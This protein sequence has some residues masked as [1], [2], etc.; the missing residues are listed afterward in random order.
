[1][2]IKVENVSKN[3][4]KDKEQLEVLKDLSITFESGKLYVIVGKSGAGKST[5][6]KC[7]AALNTIDS[8]SI[9][10]D[11]M[12]IN[13]L[14][15]KEISKFRNEKIGIVFQE[16]NLLEFLNTYENVALP[17]VINGKYNLEDEELKKKAAELL[18]FVDLSDRY[19]HYPKELSGGEQQR[20]AIA[21]ALINDPDV[22]LADEPTGSI[23]KENSTNILKLLKKISKEKC[24]I[25][26]THDDNVLKYADEIYNLKNGSLEKYESKK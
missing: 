9:S 22:I 4:I 3:F 2:K 24:V 26:V 18:E 11:D 23:D 5:F 12:E 10:F 20:I 17:L 15:D 7:L 16:F 25:I 14:N 1:M 19:K 21:R 6:L 8:G 13:N